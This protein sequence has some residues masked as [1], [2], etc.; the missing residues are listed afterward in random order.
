M[1]G[2]RC[3]ENIREDLYEMLE[4]PFAIQTVDAAAFELR[5]GQVETSAEGSVQARDDMLLTSDQ[6][7][8]R[9]ADT[10]SCQQRDSSVEAHEAP[11]QL[12]CDSCATVH[13]WHARVNFVGVFRVGVG[14]SRVPCRTV[15]RH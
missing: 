6:R 8:L 3:I 7:V 4:L 15:L 11:D 12:G 10:E 5:A 9:A 2:R 14:A 1:R 13:D